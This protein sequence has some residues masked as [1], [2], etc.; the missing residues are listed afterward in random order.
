MNGLQEL[1]LIL[2]DD[3]FV[4]YELEF[5]LLY[6]KSFGIHQVQVM[7]HPVD[8]GVTILVRYLERDLKV[9]TT[10]HIPWICSVKIDIR[11]W[12]YSTLKGLREYLSDISEL[13]YRD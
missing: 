11:S 1:N 5:S 6:I 8:C 13:K 7:L 9:S 12:F 3:G 2:D 4:P 10:E